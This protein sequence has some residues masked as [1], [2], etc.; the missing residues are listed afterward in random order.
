MRRRPPRGV[1][2]PLFVVSVGLA[3]CAKAALPL[4]PSSVAAAESRVYVANESSNSI[5]VIDASTFQVVAT[6]DA[7]EPRHPRSGPVA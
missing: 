2:L 1:I 4:P 3:G 6:I 5:T 7:E